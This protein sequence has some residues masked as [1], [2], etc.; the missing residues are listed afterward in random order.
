M[1]MS[2]LTRRAILRGTPAA[3]AA[4][5]TISLPAIASATAP[6]GNDA[7]LVDLLR[8]LRVAEEADRIAEEAANEAEW[9]ARDEFP[10]KPTI[11]TRFDGLR[12]DIVQNYEGDELAE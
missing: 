2:N 10:P 1:I 12:G 5:A 11:L 9:A 4:A 7:L 3:I 8:Q 6:A